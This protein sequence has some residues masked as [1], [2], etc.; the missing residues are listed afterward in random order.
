MQTEA[1]GNSS[2]IVVTEDIDEAERVLSALEGNLTGSI[3][4]SDNGT[5]DAAYDQLAPVLRQKTGRLLNDKMPTGVVVSPAMNHDGPYPATG[6]PGFTAVGIL[7]ALLRFSMLQSYDNVRA[8]RLP[9]ILRD[10]YNGPSLRTKPVQAGIPTLPQLAIPLP[11]VGV[12]RRI[13][14]ARLVA[15]TQCVHR[16]EVPLSS[17]RLK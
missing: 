12:G 17:G 8:H 4:S 14:N 2:L 16:S 10:D 3:Y 11:R 5:D 7:G 13:S 15:D 9:D 1:F 6:H